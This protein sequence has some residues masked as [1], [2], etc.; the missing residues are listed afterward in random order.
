MAEQNPF[1][2]IKHYCDAAV[3]SSTRGRHVLIVMITISGLSFFT[4]WNTLPSSWL[5]SRIKTEKLVLAKWGRDCKEIPA[6][7]LTP[8]QCEQAERKEKLYHLSTEIELRADNTSDTEEARTHLLKSLSAELPSAMEVVEQ[9][10]ILLK[11]IN[12]QQ[13]A[14]QKKRAVMNRL[15][16]YTGLQI[17]HDM[18]IHVPFF[19]VSVDVNDNGV[20][21]GLALV[22]I[23]IWQRFSLLQESTSLKMAFRVA[24][25]KDIL[26]EAY[27][28][29]AMRQV[30]TVV[31]THERPDNALWD[32]IP[33]LL[34]LLPCFVL[35]LVLF[36][37]IGTA[38]NGAAENLLGTVFSM[39]ISVASI[40]I[41]IFFT[42]ICL[43]IAADMGKTWNAVYEE[44][45]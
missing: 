38:V 9:R 42:I 28:Y 10:A 33:V 11:L 5:I 1:E 22:I 4:C 39:S 20:L 32:K 6:A 21:S 43:S 45:K 8:E 19:G 12:D 7:E 23:L 17:E 34:F 3:E 27:D 14:E 24:K 13:R 2:G 35:L 29:I 40:A 41:V 37:D 31:R 16:K 30:L 18:R 26:R 15:D 36:N 25:E 44:V